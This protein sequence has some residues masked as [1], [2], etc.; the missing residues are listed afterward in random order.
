VTLRSTQ[1]YFVGEK[2]LS[3]LLV[4]HFLLLDH[5]LFFFSAGRL[6]A[7]LAGDDRQSGEL[8]PALRK[9]LR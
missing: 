3:K 1:G 6:F 4:L 8:L 5:L 7:C 2:F 9:L